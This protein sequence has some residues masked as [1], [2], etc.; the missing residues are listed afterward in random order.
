MRPGTP[1]FVGERLREAREARGLSQ[2]SLGDLLTLSRQAISQYETGEI[3]PGPHVMQMI[4]ERLAMPS[5]FFRAPYEPV[6]VGTVFY[7]SM[8]SECHTERTRA[9]RRYE[10]LQQLASLAREYVDFPPVD[11]PSPDVPSDPNEISWDDIEE[12]AAQARSAWRLGDGPLGNVVWLLEGH[13]VIV[14]R[15]EFG[16]VALDAF[17]SWVNDLPCVVLGS[18]KGSAVRSRFDAAHELGHLILHRRIGTNTLNKKADFN[19]IERQAHRFAGAFLLPA[20]TFADDFGTGTLDEFLAIKLKWKVAVAAML[21]RAEDL[22]LVT[23]SHAQRLW[24]SRSRRGW[25]KREPY[26]DDI[27]LEQPYFLKRSFELMI[28]H[29]EVTPQ[30]LVQRIPYAPSD[31]ET[32]IGLQSG[33]LQGEPRP[34][35]LH[36]RSSS[37]GSQDQTVPARVVPFRGRTV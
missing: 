36:H 10:W 7:R 33:I 1:G 37:R 35:N 24:R 16:A 22:Q 3:T 2:K 18:D 30:E 15:D 25:S 29:G 20:E 9:R 8:A 28:E 19:L 31:I 17:S 4:A 6:D 5:A 12:A 32:L 21:H 26:D 27:P 23:P 11:L 14:A 34:I 13:G